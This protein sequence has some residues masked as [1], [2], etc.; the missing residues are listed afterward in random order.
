MVSLAVR[1]FLSAA[2]ISKTSALV[3]CLDLVQAFYM[4]IKQMAIALP[5]EGS[6]LEEAL[7]TFELS[8]LSDGRSQ[9][10][11]PDWAPPRGAHR[12]A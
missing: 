11:A 6:R 10:P 8:P 12:R 2:Q 9:G 4:T 3:F 5:G 1:A 7:E